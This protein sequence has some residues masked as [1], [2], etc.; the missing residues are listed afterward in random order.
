MDDKTLL[1]EITAYCEA[2]GMKPSTLGLKALGNSRFVVRLRRRIDKSEED[3]AAV[4]AFM[5]A[6]PPAKRPANPRV[7]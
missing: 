2:S 5:A 1:A 6:N 4:R 7:K 3:A